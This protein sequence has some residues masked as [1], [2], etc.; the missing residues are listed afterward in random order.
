M[1]NHFYLVRFTYDQYS[2]GYED[3]T[4]TVLVKNAPCF[5]AACNQIKIIC[6]DRGN[7]RFLDARDFE[8][9]TIDI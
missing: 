8:D 1:K 6:D 5:E 9:M 7:S 3:V 2:Q 4:E